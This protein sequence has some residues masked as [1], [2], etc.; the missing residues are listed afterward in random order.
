MELAIHHHEKKPGFLDHEKKPDFL[1][2]PG[3]WNR[4]SL[5]RCEGLNGHRPE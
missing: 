3:F 2:K 1:E 4:L 5:S